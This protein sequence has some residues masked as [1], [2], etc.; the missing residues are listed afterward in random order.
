MFYHNQQNNQWT[1]DVDYQLQLSDQLSVS[2]KLTAN[3]NGSSGSILANQIKITDQEKETLIAGNINIDQDNIQIDLKS[4]HQDNSASLRGNCGEQCDITLNYHLENLEQISSRF[5]GDAEGNIHVFGDKNA[6]DLYARHRANY[7]RNRLLSF[8]DLNV[9]FEKVGE[10]SKLKVHAS[11]I[12]SANTLLKQPFTLEAKGIANRITGYVMLLANKVR[13]AGNI[14]DNSSLRIYK[15]NIPKPY[16]LSNDIMLSYNSQSLHLNLHPT[17][18]KFA[19]NKVCLAARIG[20]KY[21]FFDFEKI[22]LRGELTLPLHDKT[23]LLHISSYLVDGNFS[24]HL[25]DT[26]KLKSNLK[27]DTGKGF[28]SNIVPNFFIPI[29]YSFDHISLHTAEK[30]NQ[31]VGEIHSPEG[32]T[33]INLNADEENSGLNL[34]ISTP[35]LRITHHHH[36]IAGS[37][38]LSCQIN[39]LTS[40]CMLQAILKNS[41]LKFTAIAPT[42]E[43]P[44]DIVIDTPVQI[45][46]SSEY[47]FDVTYQIT[48]GENNTLDIA[49]FSGPLIGNITIKSPHT[50]PTTALGVIE[51]KPAIFSLFG[52][53][54]QLKQAQMIYHNDPINT[55]MF[56]INASKNVHTSDAQLTTVSLSVFGRAENFNVDL[57]STPAPMS[58]LEMISNLFSSKNKKN[59]QPE[60]DQLTL[61]I[62]NQAGSGSGALRLIKTLSDF[63]RGLNIDSV[64]ISP[65]F[66]VTNDITAP[67]ITLKKSLFDKTYLKYQFL[68]HDNRN[69]TLSLVYQLPRNLFFELFLNR[70]NQGINLLYQND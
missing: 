34:N 65:Q 68:L 12:G 30:A 66:S 16:Q 15:E 27:I 44:S 57:K 47:A 28:L 18:L 55:P 26:L 70:E 45:K 54:I 50:Q 33:I 25:S 52:K 29:N 61:S 7:F 6:P 23:A 19:E 31:F 24:L 69:G 1:L 39:A 42:T 36:I 41:K 9:E 4:T 3:W 21:S 10:H 46:H 5:A 13:F 38:E 40:D 32:N 60:Q 22:K 48:L 63:E 51:I 2:A 37:Q 56:N 49:G 43:L 64:A 8:N 59:W 14:E 67:K 17:C 62:L 20:P 58:Q 35:N 53:T 11:D